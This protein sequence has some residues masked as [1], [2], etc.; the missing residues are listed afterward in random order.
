MPAHGTGS[1]GPRRASVA[2]FTMFKFIGVDLMV[3][4]NSVLKD[5]VHL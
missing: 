2:L 4:V 5:S 3:N 1:A